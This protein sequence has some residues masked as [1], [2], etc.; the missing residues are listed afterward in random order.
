MRRE[1][2]RQ[3]RRDERRRKKPREE[4]PD[5]ATDK[6][7]RPTLEREDTV[8]TLGSTVSANPSE[9]LP[10]E[11]VDDLSWGI[12][13][14]GAAILTMP[15]DLH[16]AIAQGLHNA[17]RLYGDAT[18]RKPVKIYGV[19]SGFEA[20][21]KEFAYGIYDGWTGLVKQP[22]GDWE[23]GETLTSKFIGLGTGLGKGLGGFVLKN[24]NAVYAPIGY[25]GK[26]L[27]K[28]V[29]KRTDGPD[30]KALIRR[31]RV[32]QGEND[33]RELEKRSTDGEDAQLQEVN[34]RV[35]YG[36]SVYEDI[37]KTAHDRYGPVGANLIGKY[38][39]KREKERCKF[40]EA[41]ESP[42]SLRGEG[43]QTYTVY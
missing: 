10:S 14:V 9:P 23:D 15:N 13:R 3:K 21:R 30:S 29:E 17:P 43:L 8:T 25:M 33:L 7:D 39:M 38:K 37:W 16:V 31:S 24:T 27:I 40:C 1:K 42:E 20:A 28:Y 41:L 19:K 5:P 26:G 6:G 32:L 35:E 2:E 34:N 36:W 11:V 12:K 18:I 4:V 22:K